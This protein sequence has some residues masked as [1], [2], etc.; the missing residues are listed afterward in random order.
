VFIFDCLFALPPFNAD[1][2]EEIEAERFFQLKW[3]LTLLELFGELS[4][5]EQPHAFRHRH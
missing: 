2:D 4:T 1:F 5:D 3:S